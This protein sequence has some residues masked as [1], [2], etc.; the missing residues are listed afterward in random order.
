[1]RAV[2]IIEKLPDVSGPSLE[3]AGHYRAGSTVGEAGRAA[4]PP[5][6]Q[7]TQVLATVA[8]FVFLFRV[9]VLLSLFYLSIRLAMDVPD[10]LI[11]LFVETIP[12]VSLKK[13]VDTYV[14]LKICCDS[15]TSF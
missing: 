8:Q 5:M 12:H 4:A 3:E 6:L 7:D 10:N 14:P 2:Y 1:M 15:Y 13:M 9:R 11:Y